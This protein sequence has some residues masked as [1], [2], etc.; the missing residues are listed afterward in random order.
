MKYYLTAITAL[1]AVSC[2]LPLLPEDQ[3]ETEDSGIAP[4]GIIVNPSQTAIY[5]GETLQLEL[6]LEPE[7]ASAKG[8]KWSVITGDNLPEGVVSVDQDGLV[9]ALKPGVAIVQAA[10]DDVSGQSFINVNKVPVY[11]S[12]VKL[13][14]DEYIL[15]KGEMTTLIA[16]VIPEEAMN[17]SVNWS[18]SD[19]SVATIDWRG[20]VTAVGIGTAVIRAAVSDDVYTECI[21]RVVKEEVTEVTVSLS[22][23]ELT[24]GEE[25]TLTADVQPEKARE[26]NPVEWTSTNTAVVTVDNGKLQAVGEGTAVVTA[27]AGYKSAS[28]TVTVNAAFVAVESL[29]MSVTGELELLPGESS[30]ITLTFVP[31]QSARFNEVQWASSDETVATVTQEG[32]VE[33]IDAGQATITA[34]S[35]SV[36]VSCTVNV[37]D[38]TRHGVDIGASVLWGMCNLG[39]KR[40]EDPGWYIAWGEIAPKNNYSWDT[41]RWA[42]NDPDKDDDPTIFH[43]LL[44]K[45]VDREGWGVLDDAYILE[46]ADESVIQTLGDGWRMPTSEEVYELLDDY[47]FKWERVTI[48]DNVPAWKVTSQFKAYEG[49]CIYFPVL[50]YMQNDVLKE[51]GEEAYYWCSDKPY[52]YSNQEVACALAVMRNIWAHYYRGRANGNMIRPVHPK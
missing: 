21:V 8:V 18:S 46:A 24:A 16:T 29:E 43:W 11:A 15:H 32:K 10:I 19:E 41:Y 7:N 50:G 6:T 49:K 12:E 25:A 51:Y 45:Y 37:V 4:E 26:D 9:T 1:L 22:A 17:N 38:I 35:G 20:T 3:E 14:K 27:T 39:A 36:Q 5:V 52:G 34:T 2:G 42:K 13:E 30:T 40:I 23:I 47:Y 44:T 33:A 31:A 28:C 48:G